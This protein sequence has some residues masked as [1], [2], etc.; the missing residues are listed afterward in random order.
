MRE[1]RRSKEMEER[2]KEGGRKEKK[3]NLFLKKF[4]LETAVTLLIFYSDS[5]I[6]LFWNR[7]WLM[8]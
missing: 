6:L 2:R 1:R 3:C 8:K 4:N 5:K 7:R